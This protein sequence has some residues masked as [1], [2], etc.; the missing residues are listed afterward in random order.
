MVTTT[1]FTRTD[2]MRLPEGF[3]AQLIDG[4][5]I[6]EPAPTIWHQWV[7]GRLYR[8]LCEKVGENRVLFS[9]VDFTVDDENVYQPDVAVFARPFSIDPHAREIETPLLVAEVLSES[10]APYDLGTKA[11]RYLEKGVQEVWLVDPEARTIEIRTPAGTTRIGPDGTA[12][13]SV[14]PGFSVRVEALLRSG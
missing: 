9:P 7:V 13:S 12:V 8:G 1:R 2:Y 5:L 6:K 10:T 14:V 4:A 3:P 11:R